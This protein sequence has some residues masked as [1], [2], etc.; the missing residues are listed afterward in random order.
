MVTLTNIKQVLSERSSLPLYHQLQRALR[1]AIAQRVLLPDDA[2]PPER[3]LAT[4][5]NV[6]RLTVRKALDGLVA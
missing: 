2:L 5:L 3:K 1:E 6:S 4:D